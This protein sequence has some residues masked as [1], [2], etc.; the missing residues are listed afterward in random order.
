MKII[1]AESYVRFNSGQFLS[2]YFIHPSPEWK[3][4]CEYDGINTLTFRYNI[5]WKYLQCWKLSNYM[6]SETKSYIFARL[7]NVTFNHIAFLWN[8]E[9]LYYTWLIPQNWKNVCASIYKILQYLLH[10]GYD[11]TRIDL[12]THYLIFFGQLIG[13]A[14]KY[15]QS[16]R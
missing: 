12:L 7:I 11:T 14:N 3:F 15:S 16:D 9:E 1:R 13:N 6:L 10:V 5:F 8:G 2:I 4:K